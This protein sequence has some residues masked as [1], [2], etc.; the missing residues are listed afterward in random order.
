MDEEKY[1]VK[2]GVLGPEGR[3]YDGSGTI[4]TAESNRELVQYTYRVVH[5]QESIRLL[6]MRVTANAGIDL[7]HLQLV[8]GAIERRVIT[9]AA[10][11]ELHGDW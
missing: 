9:D 8:F 5:T 4:R 2:P 6:D 7:G 3:T 10:I 1:N 11:N